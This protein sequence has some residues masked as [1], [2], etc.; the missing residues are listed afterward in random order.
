MLHAYLSRRQFL[1]HS[2]SAVAGVAVLGSAPAFLLPGPAWAGE[3]KTLAQPVATT[4]L[5]MCRVIFPHAELDD[6]HYAPWVQGL[7]AEAA[8]DPAVASLLGDGVR[9]L[10]AARGKPFVDLEMSTQLE[11][12]RGIESSAFFQKVRGKGVV[13]L[14]GNKA[15]WARLGYEGASWDKGGY[16]HRGFN[17][18]DWL[19]DPPEEASPKPA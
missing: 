3:L 10:D 19:P 4:L 17:D 1:L 5:Q 15:V 6:V 9:T 7:D 18:L 11:V 2:G 14:Y 12:L 16:L 13:A 8:A